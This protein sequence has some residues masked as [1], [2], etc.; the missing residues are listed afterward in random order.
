MQPQ[1]SQKHLMQFEN[2]KVNN[3]YGTIITRNMARNYKLNDFL[4]RN[5]PYC[6]AVFSTITVHVDHL[7][8][9]PLS[10]RFIDRRP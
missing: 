2:N 8:S 10:L 3:Q 6:F 7:S 4:R 9:L 1:N 5:I